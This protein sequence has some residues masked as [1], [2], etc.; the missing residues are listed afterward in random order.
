MAGNMHVATLQKQ[1]S[2]K[3]IYYSHTDHLGGGCIITGEQAEWI[4]SLDYYPF[5]ETRINENHANYN[6]RRMFTGHEYDEEIGLYYAQARYYDP[7]IGRFAGLD[8]A[9]LDGRNFEMQLDPQ[10]Q[11]LYT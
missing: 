7:A 8:P 10:Q 5:G 3:Q 2:N 4:Q 6:E 11:G 9:L 1:G